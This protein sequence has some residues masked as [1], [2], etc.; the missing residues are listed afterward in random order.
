[1]IFTNMYEHTIRVD[2]VQFSKQAQLFVHFSSLTFLQVLHLSESASSS[3]APYCHFT[4]CR[5]RSQFIVRYEFNQASQQSILG[6]GS[7]G[8]RSLLST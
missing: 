7:N 1:M 5:Y 3:L 8:Q 6:L 4:F 2:G